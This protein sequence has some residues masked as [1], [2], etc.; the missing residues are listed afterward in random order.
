MNCTPAQYQ[1]NMAYRHGFRDSMN[2]AI[3]LLTLPLPG[4]KQ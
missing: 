2:P 3:A 1:N 4:E